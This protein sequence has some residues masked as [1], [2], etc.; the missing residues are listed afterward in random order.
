[1]Q[2]C[3][4]RFDLSFTGLSE[5]LQPPQNNNPQAFLASSSTSN[6][7]GWFFDSGA[8]NHVFSDAGL[9]NQPKPYNG[10]DKLIVGNGSH[11]LISN[12]GDSYFTANRLLHLKHVLHVSSITTNLINISKFTKDNNVTIEFSSDFCVV[13]DMATKK[14]LL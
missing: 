14:P 13:K 11:L 3:Y 9:L 10:K 12:I 1:M 7:D 4:K 6:E 8:S 2:K 5:P